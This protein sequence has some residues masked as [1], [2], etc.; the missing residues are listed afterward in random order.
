MSDYVLTALGLMLVFE[1]LLPLLMPQAWR[2]TFI[3]MVTLKDGQL[4]FVGLISIVG[5]LLLILLS[6]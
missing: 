5:G 1:G 3:K 4:R 2:E 6:K